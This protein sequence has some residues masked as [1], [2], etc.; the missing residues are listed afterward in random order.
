[1]QHIPRL[2]GNSH[3]GYI[4]PK[5]NEN[6]NE[7]ELDTDKLNTLKD[8]I[9]SLTLVGVRRKPPGILDIVRRAEDGYRLTG[10]EHRALQFTLQPLGYFIGQNPST[11][12]VLIVSNEGEIRVKSK[13]GV[14]YKLRFGEVVYG[15]PDEISAAQKKKQNKANEAK[16]EAA[17]PTSEQEAEKTAKESKKAV[18][19]LCL[20]VSFVAIKSSVSPWS[21]IRTKKSR[22]ELKID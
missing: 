11:G 3:I 12:K 1:M 19:I 18:L 2:F 7:N 6:E 14:V 5:E 9:S 17:P 16:G 22:H 10:Q 8:S 15:E 20:F 21:I 4:V 13:D